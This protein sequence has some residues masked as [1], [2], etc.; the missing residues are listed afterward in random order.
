MTPLLD[1]SKRDARA[2]HTRALTSQGL[3][4]PRHESLRSTLDESMQDFLADEAIK[5]VLEPMSEH[6]LL[7]I[8]IF[9]YPLGA[10]LARSQR[11]RWAHIGLS[12]CEPLAPEVSDDTVHDLAFLG[13]KPH[14][15]ELFE[16]SLEHLVLMELV[17]S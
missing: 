14:Y 6:S 17:G 11:W 3:D 1:V 15:L 8:S 10:S 9:L 13:A 4:N 7:K 2:D 16:V 12:Y 5:R